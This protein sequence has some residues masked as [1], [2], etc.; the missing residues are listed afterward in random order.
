[1]VGLGEYSTRSLIMTIL[2]RH[3]SLVR[4][5]AWPSEV[6]GDYVPLKPRGVK[7]RGEWIGLCP[8]YKEQ[9]PSF[10]VTNVKG[11]YHCFSCGSHGNIFEFL[12]QHQGVT[13]QEAVLIVAKKYGIKLPSGK[14]N[15]TKKNIKD[16]KRR[17]KKIAKRKARKE[18]ADRESL[19]GGD[20]E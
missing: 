6:I 13:F 18:I 19:F 20:E 10:T 1:M 4:C 2:K 3:I 14:T 5:R 7:R 11:F 8:F 16:R 9:T 12:V 17:A 15:T